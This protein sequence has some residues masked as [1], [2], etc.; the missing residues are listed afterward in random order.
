MRIQCQLPLGLY[1]TNVNACWDG[2]VIEQMNYTGV[3]QPTYDLG[4]RKFI[5]KIQGPNSG[6]GPNI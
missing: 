2:S 1:G 4:L 5:C 3:A 6:S